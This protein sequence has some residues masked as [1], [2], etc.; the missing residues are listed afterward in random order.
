MIRNVAELLRL[1]MAEERKKLG[2]FKINHGP[3]IGAMYEGLTR[4]VLQTAIPDYLNLQVVSGFACYGDEMSGEIDCMLVA[5]SG[6]EV[7]RTGKFK[8]PIKD[9]VAVLEVKKT[10]TQAELLDSYDHLRRVSKL[11]GSYV[12][13]LSGKS[14]KIDI[15][16]VYRIFGQMTGRKVSDYSE[17]YAL[18][19]DLELLFH[20]LVNEYLEPVRIVIGHHGWKKE[21]TLREH[22]YKL[23]D[24]RKTN[25]SGMG[26]GS[27]PQLIIGGNYSIVKGNG[28]PYT[29]PL[30]NGKWQFLMSSSHN[31]VRILLELIF[32]KLD[33]KFGTTL[34][35]DDSLDR[36]S[37]SL[38][39]SAQ[40]LEHD[41]RS[42]WDYT[43]HQISNKALRK[44]GSTHL[45]AP[46]EL[47]DAQHV[48]FALLCK[49]KVIRVD[50]SDFAA[51]ASGEPGGAIGFV[52]SLL[53]TQLVAMNGKRLMLTTQYCQVVVTP[54]GVFAAEN[55]D[56]QLS[57]WMTSQL[58]ALAT[59]KLADRER[60]KPT[61]ALEQA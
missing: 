30:L 1:F 38:C 54:D 28:L 48:V 32:T 61:P 6:E 45:W 31:P 15:S 21:S 16:W 47:T 57:T 9:V 26:A 27:F 12:E 22:I 40:A 7:P 34:A 11:Y 5:G 36:E 58:E 29:P 4:E 55:A 2:A 56:G 52:N 50:D 51:L 24:A 25:P 33:S 10:L 46:V 20:T 35:N 60:E 8:W 49:G 23:L 59:K 13:G 14:D 44:R 53:K 37:M 17:V 41:G 19:F 43:F 42:G 3:T 39:L 18:P